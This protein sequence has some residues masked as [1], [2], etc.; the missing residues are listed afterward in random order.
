[1]LRTLTLAL[2]TLTATSAAFAQDAE[3]K[4][5]V[6]TMVQVNTQHATTYIQYRGRV[7]LTSGNGSQ[8]TVQEY[9][10]GGTSCGSKL[11][12][13]AQLALLQQAHIHGLTVAPLWKPGQGTTRCLVGFATS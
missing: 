3:G 8:A 1:M 13:D 2:L 7:Q 9:R 11:L 12:T 6:A 10:W 5:G 4:P